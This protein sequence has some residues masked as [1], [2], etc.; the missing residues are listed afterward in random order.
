MFEGSRHETLHDKEQERA[1]ELI[2]EWVLSHLTVAT[3]QSDP[4]NPSQAEPEPSAETKQQVQEEA[5]ENS[6]QPKPVE[7]NTITDTDN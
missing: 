2:K 6:E 7:G 5:L 4:E 1:R 3:A